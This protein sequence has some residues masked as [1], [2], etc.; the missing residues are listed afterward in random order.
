[1]NSDVLRCGVRKCVGNEDEVGAESA[2]M[3][4]LS[5]S[6]LNFA[7]LARSPP[8]QALL[9]QSTKLPPALVDKDAETTPHPELKS[10]AIDAMQC[11]NFTG[12]WL[13]PGPR[14]SP[15]ALLSE[16]ALRERAANFQQGSQPLLSRGFFQGRGSSMGLESWMGADRQAREEDGAGA[17]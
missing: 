17:R 13:P 9:M 5:R 14:H 12:W 2:K 11:G 10:S 15:S 7:A 4:A 1:M 16:R 3:R 8:S 6:L